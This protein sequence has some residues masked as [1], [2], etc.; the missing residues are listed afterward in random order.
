ME[1][2]QIESGKAYQGFRASVDLAMGAL[3]AIVS[4]YGLIYPKPWSQ[5]GGISVKMVYLLCTL[6]LLYGIFRLYR[7]SVQFKKTF[8]QNNRHNSTN[9]R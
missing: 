7:G 1:E 5:F 2:N 6:F 9:R 8:K 3:Y 4:M